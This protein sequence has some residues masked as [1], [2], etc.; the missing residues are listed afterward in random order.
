MTYLF[1]LIRISSNIFDY[2]VNMNLNE[3][4]IN[5]YKIIHYFFNILKYYDFYY[6]LT[7]FKFITF[8]FI[9][10]KFISKELAIRIL[11]KMQT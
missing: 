2:Y 4:K 6:Y 9:A 8:N 7:T 3:F 10:F 1:L 11:R 5:I